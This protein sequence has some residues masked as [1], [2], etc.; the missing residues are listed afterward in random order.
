RNTQ[1]VVEINL[2]IDRE[3]KDSSL[4]CFVSA[5][6]QGSKDHAW[7]NV[8]YW[9]ACVEVWFFV[10]AIEVDGADI[11]PLMLPVIAVVRDAI[12][13]K[14]Q[15]LSVIESN[16]RRKHIE[17]ERVRAFALEL[18]FVHHLASV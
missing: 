17:L 13:S 18:Q 14:P 7:R 1:E 4:R 11:K 10:A 12:T 5:P 3:L 8:V 15:P 9:I 16:R 2:W 6:V